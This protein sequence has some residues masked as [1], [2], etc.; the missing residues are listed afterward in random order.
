MPPLTKGRETARREGDFRD[1][2]LA[3]AQTVFTG[4]IVM[5]QADGF[6]VNGA[7]A[8]GLIGVGIAHEDVNNAAGAAGNTNLRF[9]VGCHRLANSAG[10]DEITATHIGAPAYVVDDQTVAATNGG[11]TRSPAGLI[12]AVDALGVWVRFDELLTNA[13]LA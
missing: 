9:R 8:A 1:E 13:Y 7:T 6:L 3:A 5:R 10:A 11:A 4:G 2:P 12:E